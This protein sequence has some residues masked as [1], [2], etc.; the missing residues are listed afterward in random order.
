MKRL[1]NFFASK[2]IRR[3][4]LG[5]FSRIYDEKQIENRVRHANQDHCGV[6][7]EKKEK[8]ERKF[9]LEFEVFDDVSN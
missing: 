9:G 5:R 4:P 8:S 7:E 6:C 2:T 3:V 1:A